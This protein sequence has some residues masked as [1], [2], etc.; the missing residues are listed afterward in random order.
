MSRRTR[1]QIVGKTEN[2]EHH[3]RDEELSAL[4]QT[5]HRAW[6]WCRPVIEPG[7]AAR[8]VEGGSQAAD[9]KEAG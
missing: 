7:L 4:E 6:L 2:Y 8:E 5:L 9:L 1:K 3:K